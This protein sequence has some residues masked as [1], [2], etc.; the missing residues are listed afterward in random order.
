MYGMTF[1]GITKD[2]VV[3]LRGVQRPAWAPIENNLVYVP[4]MPGAYHESTDV[5]P[6]P[7][8]VPILIESDNLSQLKTMT[9]EVSDWLIT[10]EPK[11][12]IFDDEPNRVYYAKLEGSGNIEEIIRVGAGVLTFTCPDPYKYRLQESGDL[13]TN[14]TSPLV[15]ENQGTVSVP[16]VFEVLLKDDITYLDI[17]GSKNYMRIGRTQDM[18]EAKVNPRQRILWDDF[19]DK[20]GWIKAAS[21][22]IDGGVIS[23]N[24]IST[25]YSLKQTDYGPVSSSWHGDA[26][27]KSVSKELKDFEVEYRIQLENPTVDKIGRVELY[28]L[29]SAKRCLGKLAMKDT[30]SGRDG[31]Y[32]EVR[33]GDKVDGRYILTGHGSNIYTWLDFNGMIKL[34]RVGNIWTAWIGKLVDGEYTARASETFEDIGNNFGGNVAYVVIHMAT[35]GS[36]PPAPM[37][38]HDL[39]V[40]EI[41]ENVDNKVEVIGNAD[42]VFT[43]DHKREVVLKNGE[44]FFKKDM[45]SKFFPLVKGDNVLRVE[46]ASAISSVKTIWREGF[47]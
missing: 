45:G 6:R 18:L 21:S 1:N 13:S 10:D 15:L 7:L 12:L 26:L 11:E 23:G 24:M 44:P 20:N 9:E 37:Y 42:D 32:V 27:I 43:F 38:I 16:P 47:H 41:N 2:F 46:P 25:G 36:H 35:I 22:D 34:K 33:V 17:I 40:F 8:S 4:E 30:K 31:N 3:V 39:K 14:L 19:G 28:L 29:D 5:K